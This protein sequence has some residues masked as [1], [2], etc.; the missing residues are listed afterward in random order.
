[1]RE[2]DLLKALSDPDN[3]FNQQEPPGWAVFFH[4][5]EVS[6]CCT[7]LRDLIHVSLASTARSGNRRAVQLPD[8]DLPMIF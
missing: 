6:K 8:V 4:D 7:V 2:D 1:M 3:G 5:D